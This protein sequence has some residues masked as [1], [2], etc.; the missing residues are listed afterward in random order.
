MQLEVVINTGA[1]AMELFTEAK[2][3]NKDGPGTTV[4]PIA[5]A[6]GII[7]YYSAIKTLKGQIDIVFNTAPLLCAG[8]QIIFDFDGL[9]DT[10][11]F[12]AGTQADPMYAKLLCKDWLAITAFVEANN[13]GVKAGVDLVIDI[14]A[15]SPWIDFGVVD[16]RGFATF[17]LEL[18]TLVDVSFD[19]S[20][21]LNEAYI[22]LQASA[23]IGVEY[24]P[25]VG[26]AGTFTIAGV[27]VAGHV[28]YK[29]VPEGNLNGGMSG[30]ITVLG[31]TAGIDL[32]VNFDLGSN[33]DNS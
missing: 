20:F 22:Y 29:S 6:T 25:D 33:S 11:M 23:A 24:E 21:K 8:G 32:N 9:N 1:W 27:S 14:A 2:I 31:I 3:L 19:P 15:K 30:S 16:V 10:W 13:A 4:P 28:H 7:G 5:V 12:S 18:H 26:S 17:N